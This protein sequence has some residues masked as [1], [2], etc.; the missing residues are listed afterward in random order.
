MNPGGIHINRAESREDIK[1]M[2]FEEAYGV[3]RKRELTQEQATSL[4]GVSAM[5]FRRYIS[6]YEEEGLEGLFDRRLHR[7]SHRKAQ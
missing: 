1:K 5:T 6:S 2:R 7:P 3:W 4:L